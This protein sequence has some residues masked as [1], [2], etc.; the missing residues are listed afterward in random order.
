MENKGKKGAKAVVTA[1]QE[2]KP[3]STTK[4]GDRRKS[5]SK[6]KG[7]KGRKASAASKSPAKG[8]KGGKAREESKSKNPQSKPKA[9]ESKGKSS[10]I[11]LIKTYR[12]EGGQKGT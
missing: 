4:S 5:A 8:G 7:S 12:Q 3:R 6:S 9:V 11:T 1:D 10:K 2:R